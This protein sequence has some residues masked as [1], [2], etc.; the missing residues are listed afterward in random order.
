MDLRRR[1]PETI[2]ESG[3]PS[4]STDPRVKQGLQF[5]QA[6]EQEGF[7]N[8]TKLKR[9]LKFFINAAEN[10]V[11]EANQ[12]IE[13]FLSSLSALP[14][15][16]VLPEP[17]VKIMRWISEATTADKQIYTVARSM[18]NTMA[19]GAPA[20]PEDK[21]DEAATRLLSSQSGSGDGAG[22]AK[23]SKMLRGSVKRLLQEAAAQTDSNE[24]GVWCIIYTTTHLDLLE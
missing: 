13:S 16:V 3:A 4:S 22:L 20:I 15:T 18:F 5:Y 2:G 12:W 8:S 11:D 6:A 17:T 24:V 1:F 21:L 7:R 14:A 9:S 10:G 19:D 23:S